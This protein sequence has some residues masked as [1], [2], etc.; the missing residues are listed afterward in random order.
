LSYVLTLIEENNFAHVG[1]YDAQAILEAA[2]T[3]YAGA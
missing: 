3:P 2:T 1:G